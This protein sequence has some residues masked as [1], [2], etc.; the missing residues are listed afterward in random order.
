MGHFEPKWNNLLSKVIYFRLFSERRFRSHGFHWYHPFNL[1][2]TVEDER[3]R[4]YKS[5]TLQ[6]QIQRVLKK[7][8]QLIGTLIA[9][10]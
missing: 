9:R 3:V 4:E 2:I 8:K 10:L 7:K 6:G 5:I 1:A